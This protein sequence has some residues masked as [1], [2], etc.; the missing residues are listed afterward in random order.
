MK[1]LF[2]ILLFAVAWSTA[3]ATP[4]N[5]ALESNGG[6]ATQSSTLSGLGNDELPQV[7]SRAIDGDTNGN[8]YTGKITHTNYEGQPWWQV[9]LG[10]GLTHISEIDIWNRTDCCVDRLNGFDIVMSNAGQIVWS[11]LN[12]SYAGAMP[13]A[14]FTL[15][16]NIIGDTVRI[17][18]E[19]NNYLSLAEVAVWGEPFTSVPEPTTFALAAV[20]LAGLGLTRRRKA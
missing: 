17:Q 13:E 16:A 8:W 3:N 10:S 7:A 14:I 18:L 1:S 19:G 11:S 4:I 5:V 20:G 2:A 12:N 6:V 15:P 9:S